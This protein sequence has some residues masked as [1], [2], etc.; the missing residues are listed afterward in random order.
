MNKALLKDTWRTID[1]T[2]SRFISLAAIVA[3]GIS[4]FAGIHATAPDMRDTATQY[5][6]DTNA[7]DLQVISTAGLTD[8]DVKVKQPD[9]KQRPAKK[10]DTQ[11]HQ[12]SAKRP[13]VH[14]KAEINNTKR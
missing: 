6:I 4:F 7:M 1:R 10:S 8:D 2:K 3:L 12:K 11:S 9:G 5:Y 14:A 13:K